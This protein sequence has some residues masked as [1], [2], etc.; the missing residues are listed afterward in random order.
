MQECGLGKH[1]YCSRRGEGAAC[2]GGCRLPCW[3]KVTSGESESSDAQEQG[4]RLWE[5]SLLLEVSPC[6]AA[7]HSHQTELRGTA[8]SAWGE[9]ALRAQSSCAAH[10]HAPGRALT[11][12][13][14]PGSSM[15]DARCK[16]LSPGASVRDLTHGSRVQIS[17]V[18]LP[19][20]WGR[21]PRTHCSNVPEASSPAPVLSDLFS[22]F[23]LQAGSTVT[24]D[25]S[26]AK[27]GIQQEA[28]KCR[29]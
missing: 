16:F 28:G 17:A 5:M 25:I 6:T 29:A 24:S 7:A 1:H 27:Q 13:H 19:C 12:V 15:G 26:G 22:S 14:E 20:S 10:R 23:P 3:S 11:A 4:E 9:T 8:T 21:R 2:A 18:A